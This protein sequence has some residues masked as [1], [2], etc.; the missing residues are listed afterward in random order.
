MSF[1]KLITLSFDD[2]TIQD[3]RL[4][5]ILNR[6][7][8]KCTFNL[9]SGRLGFTATTELSGRIVDT[10]K[11]E[12]SEVATLY[13]G[14]EIAVHTV[15]HPDLTKL[16]EDEIVRQIMEDKETLESLSGT[17]VVGMA[18]PYGGYDEMV[19][20]ILEQETPLLYA[21]TATSSNNFEIPQRFTVWHPTCHFG[22]DTFFDLADAFEKAEPEKD[23]L[24]YIW[25]HSYELD[26]GDGRWEGFE[27][28]CKRL[29]SMEGVTFV[30][31]REAYELLNV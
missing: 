13:A 19:L 22:Q 11:V 15:T 9:C 8:I 2:G 24:F 18:Y 5:E 20:Q 26:G 16:N 17:E 7:G 30:T 3:R 21:R 6:Y 4:V 31:N 12:P 1:R 27:E 10:T 29:A 14:H 25:G 23:M 28:K